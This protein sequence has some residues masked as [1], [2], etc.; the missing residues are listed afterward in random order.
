IG[1][2]LLREGLD[3]P[4]VSLVII[5]D[6]DKEGFLRNATS[7]IQIIGRCA[8]NTEGRVI[9]Y[10]DR[11]TDA[12]RKTMDETSRRREMQLV[13]NRQHGII[14]ATVKRTLETGLEEFF[15]SAQERMIYIPAL[16]GSI[17]TGGMTPEEEIRIVQEEMERAAAE[18]R[19]EEA[20]RLRDR[21]LEMKAP[22]SY[23]G[24]KRMPARARKAK[25]NSKGRK[26]R[27]RD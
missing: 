1:V 22:I 27:R 16:G 17:K 9:L 24:G 3:L 18:L 14:P 7:L 10:A 20:A 15:G 5:L 4:E 12:M 2:N 6:A 11:I 13:F 25:A 19:F 26:V 23:T 21:L 8:R